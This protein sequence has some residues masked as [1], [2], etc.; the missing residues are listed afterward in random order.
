MGEFALRGLPH[1]V[2]PPIGELSAPLA[3]PEATPPSS[4]ISN[5]QHKLNAKSSDIVSFRPLQPVI[6][7]R[8]EVA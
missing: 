6:C 4:N 2:Y 3:F 7:R 5:T 1:K 8:V